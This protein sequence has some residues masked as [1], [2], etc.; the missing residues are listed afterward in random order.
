MAN[1]LDVVLL[2]NTSQVDVQPLLKQLDG[3]RVTT[4]ELGESNGAKLS[5]AF[6]QTKSATVLVIDAS[7]YV[8]S[9]KK[10]ALDLLALVAKTEPH[11]SMIYSD[12]EIV[13]DGELQETH[14]LD[15][16]AGR[17]RDDT[18]Y[19]FMWLLNREK[20]GDVLPLD[21]DNQRSLLYELR[22][23]LSEVGR[24]AHIANR[25]SGALYTVTKLADTQNVFAYLMADK[26]LQLERERVLSRHLER[27]GAYLE[28]GQHYKKVPYYD[29]DY[30]LTATVI[31]P[32][33]NRPKFI[34]MAIESVFKQTVKEVEVIVV[35]NG[36]D[37]DPTV[38]AVQAYL[39][40]GEKYNPENPPVTLIVHDINNIGFCLNSGLEVA[41][42]KFYVQLD[43]DDQL[44]P[45]AVEKIVQV[46]EE[47]P[48]IGM[49]IG[50]Y[51]VW[52]LKSSGE[53]V[54]MDSIP[55]VTHAEWTEENGRNNLLRI[56]G[57]GAPRSF[58][59]DAAKDLGLLDMNTS[60]YARN[61]G[62]DYHFV[63]RMSEHHRIGRVWDPVYKVVRHSGG[64]DHSIDQQTVDRNN[65]AKDWMRLEALE[66]RKKMNGVG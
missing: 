56:N 21:E 14:L 7:Q 59:V 13:A 35:V 9:L 62:E 49:V 54:R 3:H 44:M 57:A 39:P 12:Y 19:G 11:W 26:E 18:D 63:L 42:G 60:P 51:E 36:G 43:S 30:A 5:D 52:E 53:L 46:Y 66:R 37:N 25:Y 48:K 28:P 33:N 45:D 47:D 32:V 10:S 29:K 2:T 15:H 17:L 50:S 8:I 20:L 24:L 64:T 61:Y 34:G 41:K 40:G 22:L 58:Y 1:Q 27:I 6:Q 16:H 55:V 38:P 23:R 65:N 4:L 31:I